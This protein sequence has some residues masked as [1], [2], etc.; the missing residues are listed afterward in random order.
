VKGDDDDCNHDVMAAENWTLSS[1][2]ANQTSIS[3]VE[4]HLKARRGKTL[5]LLTVSCM[6]W[7][8]FVVRLVWRLIALADDQ[9]AHFVT[10]VLA[11]EFHVQ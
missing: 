4:V 7:L 11:K 6:N 2:Y 10:T 8:K 5:C 3:C 1:L 9:R